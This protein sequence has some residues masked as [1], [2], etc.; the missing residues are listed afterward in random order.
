MVLMVLMALVGT[1]ADAS[2]SASAC[3]HLHNRHDDD[4]TERCFWNPIEAVRQ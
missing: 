2:A 4:G 1:I 3:I